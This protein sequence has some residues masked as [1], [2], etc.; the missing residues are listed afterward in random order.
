M[1]G[2]EKAGT[3]SYPHSPGR[4]ARRPPAW[5]ALA[6]LSAFHRPQE[7]LFCFQVRPDPF[8]LIIWEF[9][10]IVRLQLRRVKGLKVFHVLW[11]I[12]DLHGAGEGKEKGINVIIIHDLAFPLGG[13]ISVHNGDLFRDPAGNGKAV[14]KVLDNIQ[15]IGQIP[16][17]L[18][19][20]KGL[21]EEID[22]VPVL[23]LVLKIDLYVLRE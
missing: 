15:M 23:A 14:E 22:H 4:S 5:P 11:Y 21:G 17:L 16:D 8:I 6:A 9:Y 7:I 1:A 2:E 10:S 20:V 12:R 3:A 13:F 19:H 18:V